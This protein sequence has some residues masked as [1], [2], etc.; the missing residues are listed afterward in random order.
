MVPPAGLSSPSPPKI[1][2]LPAEPLRASRPGP[3][4]SQLGAVNEPPISDPLQDVIIGPAEEAVERARARADEIVVRGAA[5]ENRHTLAKV[6]EFVIAAAT[7]SCHVASICRRSEC[8]HARAPVE[9]REWK[10]NARVV[11]VVEERK[12]HL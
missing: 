6:N 4:S 1:V 7:V 10:D 2:S 9:G 8:I 5:V 3:P 11:V 12:A